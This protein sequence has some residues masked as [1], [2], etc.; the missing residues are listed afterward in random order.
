M[1]ASTICFRSSYA[2]SGIDIAR[3]VYRS[4]TVFTTRSASITLVA[5][6]VRC[7]ALTYACGRALDHSTSLR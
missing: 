2:V 7:S 1:V 4:M 3:D 5:R 6:C